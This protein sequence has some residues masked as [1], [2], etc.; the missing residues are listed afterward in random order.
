M[1]DTSTPKSN[2]P[3]TPEGTWPG[4]AA[5]PR[6]QQAT[7]AG[8][9]DPPPAPP[10]ASPV[11]PVGLTGESG[12]APS[13]APIVD[14]RQRYEDERRRSRIFL[15]TTA[16]A[17]ALLVGSLFYASAQGDPTTST[18]DRSGPGL[19]DGRGGPGMSGHDDNLD[20]RTAPDGMGPGTG[21]D[22]SDPGAR[23]WGGV[24]EQLFNADGT[25][26][27]TAVEQFQQQV[28]ALDEAGQQ[29]LA[30]HIA[31]DVTR[32]H[33]TQEQADELL[34]ALGLTSDAGT[35]TTGATA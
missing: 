31:S 5:D 34:A 21:T 12:P 20:G 30:A 11:A 15:A 28:A 16:I 8:P 19:Q 17:G 27:A 4:Q 22:P 25:M 24:L 29:Q 9:V 18:F 1:D 10:P 32:D 26:N 2:D 6:P 7:D 14:W 35:G 3:D 33:L 23:V 13:P